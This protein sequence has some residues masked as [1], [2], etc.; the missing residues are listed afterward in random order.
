MGFWAWNTGCK[1]LQHPLTDYI[2]LGGEATFILLGVTL[3]L[4]CASW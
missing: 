3:V 4:E 1:Q 2:I